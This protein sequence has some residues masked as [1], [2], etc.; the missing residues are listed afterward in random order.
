[1]SNGAKW[2]IGTT[3]GIILYVIAL[4]VW[5]HF[6]QP[7]PITEDLAPG[8]KSIVLDAEWYQVL[9][10]RWTVTDWFFGLLAAGTAVTAAVKNA[11]SS[12]NSAAGG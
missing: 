1:M 12:H 3:S 10:M 8:A 9:W 2:A 11:F 7:P 6:T 4:I 5:F